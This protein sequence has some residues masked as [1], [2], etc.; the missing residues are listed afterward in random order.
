MKVKL[1][2]IAFLLRIVASCFMV[3]PALAVAQAT[4][5]CGG[6]SAGQPAQKPHLMAPPSDEPGQQLFGAHLQR[7]MTL[8]A[9]SNSER[10]WPVRILM[11]GQSIIGNGSFT[12]LMSDYLHQQFPYA[13]IQLDNLAIGGFEGPGS[14]ARP[15][16]ISIRITLTC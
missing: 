15:S 8:L 12:Q 11:Y 6:C 7:T 4:P 10:R 13:D 5:Q 1:A 2:L 14:Y 3:V 9:T 16:T